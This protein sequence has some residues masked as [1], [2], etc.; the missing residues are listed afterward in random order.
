MLMRGVTPPS[1]Q[2]ISQ[3]P[4]SPAGVLPQG[5]P[6]TPQ[7]S[8]CLEEPEYT[9]GQASVRGTPRLCHLLYHHHNHLQQAEQRQR[10][11]IAAALPAPPPTPPFVSAATKQ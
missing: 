8:H 3:H 1:A 7:V 11:K 10:H 9:T 5:L 2:S 6:P 4:L